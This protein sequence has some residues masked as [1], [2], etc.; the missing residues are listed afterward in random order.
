MED[1]SIFDI[2]DFPDNMQLV[3]T[4]KF[5]S[6]RC[7]DNTIPIARFSNGE[8]VCISSYEDKVYLTVRY[9]NNTNLHKISSWLSNIN[10]ACRITNE[11]NEIKF[12]ITEGTKFINVNNSFIPYCDL[13]TYL[14]DG[15]SI[16][17]ACE[18]V[19]FWENKQ[20]TGLSL[21]VLQCKL[22]GNSSLK[23]SAIDGDTY[24]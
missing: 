2:Q 8:F 24:E 5:K 21:R 7:N 14:F 23:F 22:C 15:A 17:I 18:F 4:G 13:K 11:N 9:S 20:S 12:K 6:I 3:G 1:F 16:L 10:S 19:C